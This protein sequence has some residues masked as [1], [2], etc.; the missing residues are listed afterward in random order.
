MRF[1]AHITLLMRLLTVVV[2]QVPVRAVVLPLL[3]DEA[4][5]ALHMAVR[6]ALQPLLSED[7]MWMQDP[8]I[9]HSTLFHASS[10]TVRG[11]RCIQ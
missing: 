8:A 10:H 1:C 2:L 4:A 5:M 6:G 7:S 9:L 11:N 3:D